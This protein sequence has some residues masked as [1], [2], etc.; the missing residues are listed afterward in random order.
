MEQPLYVITGVSR[1]TGERTRISRT[2]TKERAEMLIDALRP[3]QHRCSEYGR[4]KVEPAVREGDLFAQPAENR[5]ENR[6]AP[7]GAAAA[8]PT[9]SRRGSVECV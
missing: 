8:C 7:E 9:E 1:L 2:M 6:R 3:Q 4:L 5:R